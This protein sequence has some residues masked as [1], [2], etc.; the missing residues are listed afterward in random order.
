MQNADLKRCCADFYQDKVSNLLFGESMHP[1]ALKLTQ[2]LGTRLALQNSSRVLDVAC[3][4]GTSAMFLAKEFG[5]HVMGLDLAERNIEEAKNILSASGVSEL[6]DFRVGDAEAINFEDQTF[7]CAV[8]E[9]SLCLFPNKKK[10]AEEMYRV[11]KNG[12][13]IGI[14]DIVVRGNIPQNLRDSLYRFV[15]VLE[16]ENDESYKSILQSAGFSNFRIYDKKN[17]IM[18][19]IDD[20]NKKMFAI[21]LLKGLGK[22]ELQV[23]LERIKKAVKEVSECINSGI[24]SYIIITGEKR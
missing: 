23:D 1:G 2:E 3:G 17:A 10:A 8:C 16:A 13:R 12:G 9:C 22:L 7:D 20:I 5:C 14:S 6:V 19:L 15:C 24:I 4:V 18:Q 11:T 21:E